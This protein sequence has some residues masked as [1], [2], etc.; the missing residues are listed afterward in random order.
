MCGNQFRERVLVD[1]DVLGGESLTKRIAAGCEQI[2]EHPVQ[3][4][5]EH[6]RHGRK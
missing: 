2:E 4:E 3:L 5:Q 6:V 1:A